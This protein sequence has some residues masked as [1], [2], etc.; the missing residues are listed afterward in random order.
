MSHELVA[1]YLCETKSPVQLVKHF[2]EVPEGKIEYPIWVQKKYD[3]IYTLMVVIAG[4]V[5]LYSRTGKPMYFEMSAIKKDGYHNL[6]DGCYVAE[7][8]NDLYH[9]EQ[10][11]GL[12]NTNRKV[13]WSH[14]DY[15]MM[16]ESTKFYFHD[17]LTVDELL[18]GSSDVGWDARD[19]TLSNNLEVAKLR[20]EFWVE[21][22][23]FSDPVSVQEFADRVI[24]DGYEG[25]VLKQD[26]N[27][28]AGHK[29]YRT[30]KIVKGIS[31]D[32]LCVG[33]QYGKGKRAGQIAA[34]VLQYGE[35]TFNADLG[36]GWTDVRR[37]ELTEAH[38]LDLPD[39]PVGEIWEVKALQLS[40]TGKALRLP[41]V[42]RIRL[43]KE[44]PDTPI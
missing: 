27:W 4:E 23:S 16:Y 9:L 5:C 38:E 19:T 42:I 32:L 40:S 6:P 12:V 41:K 44:A 26:K 29:G 34:L 1:E 10:L 21:A 25:L 3:G 8:C 39:A 14:T 2:N 24:A 17:Y 11:A 43:D 31:L 20:G 13:L 15:T 33:V 36:K 18:G 30:M 22:W 37:A 28:V 7:M 35:H